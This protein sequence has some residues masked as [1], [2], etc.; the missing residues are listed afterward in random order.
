MR[1]TSVSIGKYIGVISTLPL[2]ETWS[3]VHWRG[4]S[5]RTYYDL[6]HTEGLCGDKWMR[7]N[8]PGRCHCGAEIPEAVQ[9]FLVLCRGRN[10]V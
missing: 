8:D 9:G 10:G 5:G 6:Q 7:R 2:D 3:I 4:Q 1:G